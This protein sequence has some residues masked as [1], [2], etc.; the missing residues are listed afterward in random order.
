MVTI[1]T[2]ETAPQD[3]R[4]SLAAAA[5]QFGFVPDALA[6]MAE[7]PALVEAF[8]LGNRAFSRTGFTALEREVIIMVIARDVGCDV[9]EAI[10]L[11]VL[12]SVD[13]ESVGRA[14]LRRQ[15]LE[16][17]RL[18]ALA[19]FTSRVLETRGAA[20]D[21]D[22][23]AFFAAGWT[24]QSALEVVVGVGTYTL[25]TFANRMTRARIDPAFR[26]ARESVTEST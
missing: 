8:G 17:A 5:K 18:G 11:S 24:P 9:C 23:T 4:S 13:G 10:H 19:R 14:I 2:T 7:S 12:Q 22:L 16:D 25:S 15:P 26:T 21:D 1:H 6:R 3:S 20:D